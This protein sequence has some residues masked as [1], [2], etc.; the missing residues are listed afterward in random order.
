VL[1]HRAADRSG[2]V[3]RLREAMRATLWMLDR[4]N[5]LA[6]LVVVT[7]GARYLRQAE[8]LTRHHAGLIGDGASDSNSSAS[9]G[10]PNSLRLSRTRYG[11]LSFASLPG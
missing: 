6:G 1:L 4:P 2:P 11:R 9:R 5:V 7:L 8:L 10:T 3:A